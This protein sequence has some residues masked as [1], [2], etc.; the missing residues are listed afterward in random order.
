MRE[1]F[2]DTAALVVACICA[3]AMACGTLALATP[4]NAVADEVS[5]PSYCG[6][7][8][9]IMLTDTGEVYQVYVPDSKLP[10][11]GNVSQN[12]GQVAAQCVIPLPYLPANITLNTTLSSTDPYRFKRNPGIA[13]GNGN[14][15]GTYD[16]LASNTDTGELWATFYAGTGKNTSMQVY[17]LTKEARESHASNPNPFYTKT[18]MSDSY[19]EAVGSTITGT[20]LG[21][22][23]STG[24]AVDKTSGAYYVSAVNPSQCYPNA[25]SKVPNSCSTWPTSKT[26]VL[27]NWNIDF[28]TTSGGTPVKA[29]TLSLTSGDYAVSNLASDIE[30]DTQGNLTL[31]LSWNTSNPIARYVRRI[32][33]P[34]ANVK[35]GSF[36]PDSDSMVDTNTSLA[37]RSAELGIMNPYISGIGSL[38]D[39]SDSLTVSMQNTYNMG[40]QSLYNLASDGTLTDVF[41]LP[42]NPPYHMTADQEGR[43]KAMVLENESLWGGGSSQKTTNGPS[44]NFWSGEITDI[45][46]GIGVEPPKPYYGSYQ[47]K[48]IDDSNNA[49]DGAEF[50]MWPRPSDGQCGSVPTDATSITLGSDGKPTGK[51]TATSGSDGV[52]L[53]SNVSLGQAKSSETKSPAWFCVVE[54]KAP[55][56]FKLNGTPWSVELQPDTITVGQ[57]VTNTRD[58]GTV[59]VIKHD[60]TTN[61]TLAGAQFELIEDTNNDGAV[62]SGEPA[63]QSDGETKRTTPADGVLTWTNVPLGK[64]YIVH[65]VKAPTGYAE[66]TTQND[67]V[68]ELTEA[69][70][71][72]EIIVNN[73][74]STGTLNWGKYDEANMPKTLTSQNALS[75]SEWTLTYTPDAGNTATGWTKTI[76][77]CTQNGCKLGTGTNTGTLLDTNPAGGLF[78]VSDLE[79]GTYT[80]KETKAPLGY[81]ITD[82]TFTFTIDASHLTPAA[83]LIG[84]TQVSVPTLPASGGT[85]ADLYK[86]IAGG[87][88]ACALF[89]GL[90]VLLKNKRRLN[91]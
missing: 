55:T 29:G 52:V 91:P 33:I 51:M 26:R 79:W 68:V 71:T 84:D 45:A 16:A 22:A 14:T 85:S 90:G 21:G 19:W 18:G 2:A 60:G 83:A 28:Y 65:E 25:N 88:F 81:L 40:Y 41:D 36:T 64:K 8:S 78:T 47:F 49:L 76:T 34:A 6:D 38:G 5:V 86:W 54:T 32:H 4:R 61:K 82:K 15:Q 20:T 44:F 80:L 11:T 27:K 39:S 31:I 9:V 63:V 37:I 53:F 48:K 87:L 67:H 24:G 62:Q 57:D 56:N 35:N 12:N 70:K 43:M 72:V 73:E 7:K 17:R 89:A 30:F 69:S 10:A 50:T 42:G 75:G 46:D 59:K 3:I 74:R 66:A 13:A 23:M 77:D 58:T 1:K